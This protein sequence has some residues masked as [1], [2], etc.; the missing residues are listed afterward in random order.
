[1]FNCKR[2][3]GAGRTRS[4]FIDDNV[5]IQKCVCLLARDRRCPCH[6]DNVTMHCHVEMTSMFDPM[7]NPQRAYG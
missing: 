3:L 7:S 5:D 4:L 2:L 6:A 1:M